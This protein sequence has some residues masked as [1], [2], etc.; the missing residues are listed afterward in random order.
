MAQPG[1]CLVAAWG[2]GAWSP[3]RRDGGKDTAW[4][5]GHRRVRHRVVAGARSV[6]NAAGC[7]DDGRTVD[8]LAP[9]AAEGSGHAAKRV[10]EA[11]AAS[12]PTISEWG[13][14][15]GFDPG[16]LAY[17]GGARGEL[18]HLSTCRNREDSLSSGERTGRSPNRGGVRAGRRC[19]H[20]GR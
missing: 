17:A 18:K 16:H 6:G 12:D 14:P 15:P 5:W 13:N 9:S 3:A 1:A 10:G 20:G 4:R 19:R 7:C 8:A 2:V 11:L